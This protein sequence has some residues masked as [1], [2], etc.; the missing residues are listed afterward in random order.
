M[1][2]SSFGVDRLDI[3]TL[4]Y[5]VNCGLALDDESFCS[6]MKKLISYIV[7]VWYF[8]REDNRVHEILDLD[9]TCK[10]VEFYRRQMVDASDYAECAID[11]L[12][13]GIDFFKF[14]KETIEFY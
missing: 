3:P 10:I 11:L 1:D 2:I 9:C 6:L 13:D 14:T 5:G 4:C 12:F 7:E 8:N